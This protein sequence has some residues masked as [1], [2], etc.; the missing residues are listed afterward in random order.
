ME[1]HTVRRGLYA[2]AFKI[3]GS[4]RTANSPVGPELQ[5]LHHILQ[6]NE[7]SHIQG[8]WIVKLLG[9]RVCMHKQ[10][11]KNGITWDRQLHHRIIMYKQEKKA[12]QVFPLTQAQQGCAERVADARTWQ[13]RQA[14][15]ISPDG[16]ILGCILSFSQLAATR[17]LSRYV[18]HPG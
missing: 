17:T 18:A 7:L 10:V 1:P 4:K 3:G 15:T 13:C 8:H 16:N 14:R 2:W 9:G 11:H 6:G 12:C 5:L